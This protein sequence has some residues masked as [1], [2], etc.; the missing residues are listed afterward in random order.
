MRLKIARVIQLLKC[1]QVLSSRY[2]QFP[3]TETDGAAQHDTKQY[4]F[5]GWL[6]RQK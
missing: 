1:R 2:E 3:I 6:Q 5:T 4:D